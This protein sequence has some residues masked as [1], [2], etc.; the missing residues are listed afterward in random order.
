MHA[1]SVSDAVRMHAAGDQ[2]IK[3]I[4]STA[5]SSA[6]PSAVRCEALPLS[7]TKMLLELPD[8]TLVD[9]KQ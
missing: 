6:V 8:M 1:Y 4:Y 9:F 3:M 2:T 5:E 7:T